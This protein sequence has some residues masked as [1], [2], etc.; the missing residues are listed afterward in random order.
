MALGLALFGP[1]ATGCGVDRATDAAPGLAAL[2]RVHARLREIP[3]RFDVDPDRVECSSLTWW[4]DRLLLVPQQPHDVDPAS[5]PHWYVLER[6]AIARFLAGEDTTAL[7]PVRLPYHDDGLLEAVE[8]WDGIE[9]VAVVGDRVVVSVERVQNGVWGSVL[10]GGTLLDAPPRVQLDA[11]HRLEIRGDSGRRNFSEEALVVHG[12]TLLTLHELNGAAAN[13]RRRAHHVDLELQVL[14]SLPMPA[15]E[16]RITDATVADAE[17]RFWVTNQYWPPE[18]R[19]VRPLADSLAVV[20]RAAGVPVERIVGLRVNGDRI[21]VD[22]QG[23]VVEIDLRT[24][25]VVRNWEG[26][27]RWDSTG[28]LIATDRYP[29]T[30][31]AFVPRR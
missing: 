10:A 27:A 26:I 17:G 25:G 28:F 22:R 16:Y 6:A 24:D 3:L 13:P 1:H 5:A 2:A 29:R 14:G 9:A 12:S 19:E 8:G 15:I 21:E 20:Q 31:L 4:G 11:S 30:M 7:R 18:A 23:G